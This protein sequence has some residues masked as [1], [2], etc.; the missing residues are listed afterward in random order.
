MRDWL[1]SLRGA[2]RGVLLCALTIGVLLAGAAP[3]SA[4]GHG[5]VALPVAFLG[6]LLGDI[7]HAVLGGV[8]W[9]VNVAGDFILNLIGGLVRDLIPR[10]WI[11]K[12]LEI[13]QWLVTVPN[14]G[15]RITGPGGGHS[16]GFAGV[17]A[18]RGLYTWLGIAIAPLT[19]V[20]ATSR[21]WSGQGDPPSLP[22]TR[23][24]V[25]GVAL[26]N[27]TWLWGQ[28][29]ALTNQITHAILGVPAVTNGV[30]K[31]FEVLIA[32]AALGGLQLVGL[33]VMGVGA[34]QLLAL[35]FVKVVLI[36]VG[37][38]VFAIGPLLLGLVATD[39]GHAV[40]RTWL[41][42]ALGLFVLP[43]LWASIFAI[44]AVLINDASGGSEVLGAGSGLGR[45]LGGLLIAFAAIA[46]FWL[47]IKLTK[48]FGSL[49]SGQLAGLLALART[50]GVR[51]LLGGGG[52]GSGSRAAGSGGGA[53]AGGGAAAV[54]SLRGFASKVGGAASGA[55]GA[56]LPAGR[57]GAAL[58]GAGAGAGT[59]A[60]GGLL[61]AGGALLSKGAAGA[62]K[63]GLARGAA[64][65]RAG[66]VA[67]RAARG[68]QRGWKSAGGAADGA[69]SSRPST[70][71]PQTPTTPAS[72]GPGAP[73]SPSNRHPVGATTA[74][75][76]GRTGGG[77]EASA[78]ST[79]APAPSRR[80][81]RPTSAPRSGSPT[82]AVP[83]DAGRR[84]PG[85]PSKDPNDAA[86]DAFGRAP[87]PTRSAR[88]PFKRGPRS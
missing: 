59:L 9:T 55:A 22:I 70:P 18:M 68:A 23:V 74:T 67:T 77:D 58:A 4:A 84:A 16:Y 42:M 17:N 80:A 56:L 35:L 69:S 73:Q 14:Y 50:G 79:A 49:A 40:A 66:A 43:V 37:A 2:R 60:R 62:A 54:A 85:R 83:T 27:Y 29:V 31:M 24:L 7:G 51:G 21:A 3:A 38:L 87:R 13:M 15:A 57:A 28:A 61:G 6:G 39:R 82:P 75:R 44:A 41:T 72:G 71:T 65:T 19:L 45:I 78:S 1:T 25:V 34:V 11:E 10:S 30:Q 88:R 46:G 76:Q 48:A 63:S 53:G 36:L 47:N 12:G 26:L 5:A 8:D 64:S 86:R 20:Y 52:A 33:L 32:G 81:P